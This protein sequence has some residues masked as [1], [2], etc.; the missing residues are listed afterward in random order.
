[1]ETPTAT[2]VRERSPLLRGKYP[3]PS[4]GDDEDADFLAAIEDT[5]VLVGM[6]TGRLIEPLTEGVEVPPGLVNIAVRA[7]AKWSERV[8]AASVSAAAATAAS[9]KML[10]SISAGPWSES[11]FA[12]G[13]LAMKNGI[14]AITGDPSLDALLWALMTE[15]RRDEWIAMATGIQ[16]P[17]AG[18]IEFDYRK[19]GAGSGGVAGFGAG[20]D[21]F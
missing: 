18:M 21:G 2:Q 16:P 9:G 14:V 3:A 12:P 6:A 19:M 10:R 11:Y 8:D 17:A 15:D 4:G 20:P 7:V 13:E 5:A 1:M